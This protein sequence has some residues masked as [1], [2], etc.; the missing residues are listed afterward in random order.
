M[1]P[2]RITAGIAAES[3]RAADGGAEGDQQT[4]DR[5]LVMHS[6]PN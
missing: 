5:M 3:D 2:A 4:N 6:S 1:C